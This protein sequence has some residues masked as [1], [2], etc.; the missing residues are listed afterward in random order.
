MSRKHYVSL[1]GG[2]EDKESDHVGGQEVTEDV[3]AGEPLIMFV[4]LTL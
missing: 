3:D 4:V 2:E 1:P